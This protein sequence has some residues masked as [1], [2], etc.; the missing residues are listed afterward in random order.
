MREGL[1]KKRGVGLSRSRPQAIAGGSRGKGTHRRP[2]SSHSRTRGWSQLARSA[3]IETSALRIAHRCHGGDVGRENCAAATSVGVRK[4]R[5]EKKK[6]VVFRPFGQARHASGGRVEK[7]SLSISQHWRVLF[8]PVGYR[9]HGET[10][11]SDLTKW[12]RSESDQCV[13]VAAIIATSS[14]IAVGP[15]FLLFA[16]SD[17]FFLFYH[18]LISFSKKKKKKTNPQAPTPTPST[19]RASSTLTRSLPSPTPS[20]RGPPTAAPR[21]RPPLSSRSGT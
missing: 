3:E 16:P 18:P 11:F 13:A 10:C 4:V 15:L 20:S 7:N 14:K 17:P 2:A 6:R 21:T 12:E 1:E 19:R 8:T 5:S 9:R